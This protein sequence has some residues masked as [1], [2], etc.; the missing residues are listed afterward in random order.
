[1]E[2]F[3]LY[4]NLTTEEQVEFLLYLFQMK[5]RT[6]DR[7]KSDALS[8]KDKANYLYDCIITEEESKGVNE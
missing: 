3:E 4:K 2:I 5:K 8:R 6:S 7:Q 1:M